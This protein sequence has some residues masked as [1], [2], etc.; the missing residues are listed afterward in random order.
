MVMA[1]PSAGNEPAPAGVKQET[2]LTHAEVDA[3]RKTHGYN[4]V[5]VQ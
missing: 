2:G 5:A 1:S 4:E 3:L